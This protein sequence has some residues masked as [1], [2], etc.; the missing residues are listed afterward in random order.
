MYKEKILNN[1]KM[2]KVIKEDFKSRFLKKNFIFSYN[3]II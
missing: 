2:K 3:K 1:R